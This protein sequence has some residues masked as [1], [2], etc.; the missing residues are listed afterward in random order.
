MLLRHLSGR[1]TWAAASRDRSGAALSVA[2]GLRPHRPARAFKPWLGEPG[3]HCNHTLLLAYYITIVLY[4]VIT[5]EPLVR[6]GAFIQER[7]SPT[8]L[9]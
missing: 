4:K 3:F 7:L 6:K 8:M 1:Y 5:E 2:G 9:E